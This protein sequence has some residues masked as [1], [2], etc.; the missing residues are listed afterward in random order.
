MAQEVPIDK[1]RR[2]ILMGR[3]GELRGGNEP[4]QK[5][6]RYDRVLGCLMGGNLMISMVVAD[7][8]GFGCSSHSSK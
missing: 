1:T 3:D 4:K 6:I 2:R 5:P 8:G 7:K